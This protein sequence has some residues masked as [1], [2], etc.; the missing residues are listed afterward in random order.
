VTRGDR[1]AKGADR[2]FAFQC[3]RTWKSL[4]RTEDPNV[5]RCDECRRDVHLC[6]TEDDA[7]MLARDHQCIAIASPS[8]RQTRPLPILLPRLWGAK[9]MAIGM[10]GTMVSVAWLVP[11]DG[12]QAGQTIKLPPAPFTLG[13]GPADVV[14]ADETLEPVQLAFH[15]RR[16]WLD[17]Y[18]PRHPVGSPEWQ[19]SALGL[20]DGKRFTIGRTT[21]VFKSTVS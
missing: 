19:A 20:H 11:L 7:M 12:P 4:T 17:A 9:T 21:F 8:A 18:D 10:F 16:G 13:R 2:R 5:R 6:S 14:L 3:H 15:D 1:D